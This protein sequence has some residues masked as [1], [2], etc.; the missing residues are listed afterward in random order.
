MH[1]AAQMASKLR[2]GQ[3]LEGR[4]GFYNILKP[5]SKKGDDLWIAK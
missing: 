4:E 1:K 2:C 5:L 3:R